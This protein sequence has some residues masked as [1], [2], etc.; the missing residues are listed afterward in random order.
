MSD[1]T[2]PDGDAPATEITSFKIVQISNMYICGLEGHHSTLIRACTK[3]RREVAQ[4]KD[5]YGNDTTQGLIT[6]FV[7]KGITVI[8]CSS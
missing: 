2:N 3:S 7:F 8:G 6:H 5:M 4:N 1:S